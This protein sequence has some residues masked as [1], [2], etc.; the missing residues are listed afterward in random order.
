MCAMHRLRSHPNPRPV[1]FRYVQSRQPLA[2]A[3]AHGTYEKPL[4]THFACLSMRVTTPGES[5]LNL[6]IVF[7]HMYM[8]TPKCEWLRGASIW[9]DKVLR[10]CAHLNQINAAL[11]LSESTMSSCAL[12]TLSATGIADRT[13][14]GVFFLRLCV[15]GISVALTFFATAMSSKDSE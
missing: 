3:L 15:F 14:G 2:I 12:N 8:Y 5:N 11:S 6:I 10:L 9:F 4:T 7:I 13:L 1:P